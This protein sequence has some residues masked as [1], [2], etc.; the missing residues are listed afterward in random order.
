MLLMISPILS[1][2]IVDINGGT[3]LKMV[4]RTDFS[5]LDER[6]VPTEDKAYTVSQIKD[7]GRRVKIK[8]V[9][10]TITLTGRD[11]IYPDRFPEVIANL[12][13]IQF[14]FEVDSEFCCFKPDG[15]GTNLGLIQSR[16]HTRDRFKIKLMA[17]MMPTMPV[18]FDLMELKDNNLRTYGYEKRKAELD[19]AFSGIEGIKVA[20]DFKT[21]QEAWNHAEAHKLEGIVSKKDVPYREGRS[22][23]QVKV[24]RKGLFEIRFTSYQP[25]VAGIKLFS[26]DGFKCQCAGSQSH[27]VM[28][29]LDE[30]G[31]VDV[32]VRGMKD[33][34]ARNRIREPVFFELKGWR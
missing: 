29:R 2:G 4:R 32:V 26:E 10:S 20:K 7:D 19:K 5:L 21:P 15:V 30:H 28:K 22:D 14:D 13:K 16:S 1:V 24:K 12:Q 23:N 9:G 31:F 25:N 3:S 6:D 11:T 18:L 8:K 33:R 34:T 17:K 27:E